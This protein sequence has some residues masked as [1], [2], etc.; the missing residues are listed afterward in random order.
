MAAEAYR[1]ILQ[2]YKSPSK[3]EGAWGH[4]AEMICD[5]QKALAANDEYGNVLW[6]M[7]AAVHHATKIEDP[8]DPDAFPFPNPLCLDDYDF[9]RHVH[10]TEFERQ[11]LLKILRDGEEFARNLAPF[12]PAIRHPRPS[13][14]EQIFTI[15]LHAGGRLTPE[16]TEAVTRAVMG[17]DAPT[18]EGIYSLI[19]RTRATFLKN[20]R[21]DAHG[22]RLPSCPPP[23]FPKA[24]LTTRE[25]RRLKHGGG[26]PKK[27]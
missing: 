9:P 23:S 10:L 21:C 24:V 2:N 5:I 6:W 3:A 8:E 14:F 27:N 26:A 20:G 17:T 11:R 25:A 1:K 13:F 19:R 22:D 18:R 16:Y 7:I 12:Y 4:R 15:W